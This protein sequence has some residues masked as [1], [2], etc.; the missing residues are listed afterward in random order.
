MSTTA[1]DL[2]GRSILIVDDEPVFAR[3]LADGLTAELPGVEVK[4][5]YHGAAALD[6][7]LREP[8]D[9]VLTDVSMPVM[10]G[11]TLVAQ[12][13]SHQLHVPVIMVTAFGTRDIEL[14]ARQHGVTSV[15]DKPI[16]FPMLV[17]TCAGSLR[18]RDR[19]AMTGVTLAGLLQLLEMERRTCRLY[20]VGNGQR[21]VVDMAEGKLVGCTVEELRGLDA[22][23]EVMSWATPRI[24]LTTHR[25]DRQHDPIALNQAL[26]EA[27]RRADEGIVRERTTPPKPSPEPPAAANSNEDVEAAGAPSR[28]SKAAVIRALQ[29]GASIPGMLAM[30]VVDYE[31]GRS[32]GSRHIN[33]FPIDVAAAGN[34]SVVRA[35]IAVM[36]KLGID[37]RLEDILIT[38]QQQYH[39]ITPLQSCPIFLYIALDKDRSN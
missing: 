35:K 24:E 1:S 3:T 25:G 28:I 4:I 29:E 30:A 5:A 21:G 7:L 36:N 15:I 16:D 34:A 18:A 33:G 19:A 6:V 17:Q 12:M 14:D 38:L 31:S 39:V 20:I 13:V 11:M 9:L 27:A 37:A 22:L 26:L 23:C 2:A 10:D 8:I 32:L